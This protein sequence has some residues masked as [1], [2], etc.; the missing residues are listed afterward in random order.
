MGKHDHPSLQFSVER[1]HLVPTGPYEAEVLDSYA[2]R[3]IVSV[4][5]SQKRS[6]PLLKKYWSVLRDVVE[7]CKT[8]WNSRDEASDALKL[9]LGVTD[10]GKS[11]EGKWFIRPGSISF[12]SMDEPAFRDYFEKAMAILARVT[13]I[14]P[15][16]LSKRYSHIPESGPDAPSAPDDGSGNGAGPVEK[17]SSGDPQPSSPPPDDG[18]PIAEARRRGAEAREKGMSRKAVP[19]DLRK[20]ERL[21][22]A[23]FDGFDTGEAEDREPGQEG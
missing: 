20:D 9:A 18:D 16:E 1:G 8:P 3:S 7:N 2:P 17:P 10:I 6:L 23:Y 5:L 19:A 21:L 12:D 14:D 4:T 22:T 13:G 15:D 11:V